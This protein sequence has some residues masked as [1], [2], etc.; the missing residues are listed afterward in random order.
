MPIHFLHSFSKETARTCLPLSQ[1]VCA[2]ISL[3]LRT[4]SPTNEGSL[5]LFWLFSN[6]PQQFLECWTNSLFKPLLWCVISLSGPTIA[7]H[8]WPSF[9]YD[10]TNSQA[11]STHNMTVRSYL[12]CLCCYSTLGTRHGHT[13]LGGLSSQVTSMGALVAGS[14]SSGAAPLSFIAGEEEVSS[15]GEQA[16]AG[17]AGIFEAWSPGTAAAWSVEEVVGLFDVCC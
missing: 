12:G 15:R 10:S 13:Y 2:T 6:L 3:P 9:H 11:T 17:E 8:K 4:T 16:S 5:E 14:P 7:Y 1:V